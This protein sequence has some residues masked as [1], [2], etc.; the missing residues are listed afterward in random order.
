MPSPS[1]RRSLARG[2]GGNSMWWWNHRNVWRLAPLGRDHHDA[3]WVRR[4][5]MAF[6]F[7]VETHA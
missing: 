7:E 3:L 4:L 5:Y 6:D 1:L 2:L